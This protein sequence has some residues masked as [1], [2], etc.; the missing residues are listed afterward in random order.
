MLSMLSLVPPKEIHIGYV[1]T[2]KTE[3]EGSVACLTY[4]YKF[5]KED[6][7][8]EVEMSF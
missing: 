5:R 2:M 3:K 1:E 7:C 6:G 8:F 4:V